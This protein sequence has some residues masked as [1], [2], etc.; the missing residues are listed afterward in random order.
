MRIRSRVKSW[1][2]PLW[3]LA[4]WLIVAIVPLYSASPVTFYTNLSAF[5]AAVTNPSSFGFNN[6]Q[7]ISYDSSAGL[8]INNFNFVGQ[9]TKSGGIPA[10]G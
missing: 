10:I 6:V 7:Q 1:R 2:V 3:L 9:I 5:Q 4:G 8:T